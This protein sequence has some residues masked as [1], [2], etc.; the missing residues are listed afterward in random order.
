MSDTTTCQAEYPQPSG[1]KEGLGFPICRIVGMIC[2]GSG[3]LLDAAIGPCKGKGSDEQTLL[4]TLLGS[5]N[6]ND[7]LMGDAFYAT[8][9]LLCALREKGVDGVFEQHGARKLKTDF[10]LGQQL[11]SKDHLVTLNKPKKPSWM[12]Q[13]DYEQ[14]PSSL[15]VREVRTGGKTRNFSISPCK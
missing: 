3:A 10:N 6:E 5:L 2:L 7:I 8:Y 4:R 1:Q 11:G 15:V 12:C 13:E 9:F 14:A